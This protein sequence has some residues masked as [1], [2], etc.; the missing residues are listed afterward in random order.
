MPQPR[1]RDTRAVW[2]YHRP[3]S[4]AHCTAVNLLEMACNAVANMLTDAYDDVRFVEKKTLCK[5]KRTRA[6]LHWRDALCIS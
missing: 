3:V 6:R 2:R 1:T 4:D 5:P